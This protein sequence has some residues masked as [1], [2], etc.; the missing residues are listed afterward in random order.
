MLNNFGDSKTYC[1]NLEK[2][3]LNYLC[4]SEEFFSPFQGAMRQGAMRFCNEDET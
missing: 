2:V 1:E 4:K 3:K